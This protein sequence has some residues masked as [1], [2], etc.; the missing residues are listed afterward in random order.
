MRIQQEAEQAMRIQE[1]ARRQRE[2]EEA[3]IQQAEARR[4]R[5]Q[6][7]QAEA[8]AEAKRLAEENAKERKK[9]RQKEKAQLSIIKQS[10]ETIK[11]GIDGVNN[12]SKKIADERVR[13]T[14]EAEEKA[15]KEHLLAEQVKEE[16]R[17]EQ[18]AAIKATEEAKR[19]KDEDESAR[20]TLEAEEAAKALAKA[21]EEAANKALAEENAKALAKAEADKADEAAQQ[22]AK[23]AK[24][25]EEARIVAEAERKQ[26][27]EEDE[28]E[29]EELRILEQERLAAERAAQET[30][31]KAVKAAQ[32]AAERIRLLE[33]EQLAAERVRLLEQQRI[34]AE[35]AK[36]QA[37][38][39]NSLTTFDNGIGAVESD[40]MQEDDYNI[41]RVQQPINN[42]TVNNLAVKNYNTFEL[43]GSTQTIPAEITI[44][45]VIVI[46]IDSCN[47]DFS[48]RETTMISLSDKLK[49]NN[50]HLEQLTPAHLETYLNEFSDIKNKNTTLKITMVL[51]NDKQLYIEGHS[52]MRF[53]DTCKEIGKDFGKE[54]GKANMNSRKGMGVK[55]L[56][57]LVVN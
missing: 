47:G 44:P 5:E 19:L 22:A 43:F 30:Q 38:F 10:L 57:S 45:C 24:A 40:S 15:R 13:K 56:K 51:R 3:R 23:A 26:K 54:I 16:K 27:Q 1:E 11:A 36:K 7:A 21:T 39:E 12:E 31:V 46:Y 53:D 41:V 25:A 6:A 32:E 50:I 42:P 33:Q 9:I 34:A 18:E 2:A 8:A 55:K 37:D 17:K 20:K 35:K 52:F 29:A 14:A 4:L 49:L 28:R 48:L